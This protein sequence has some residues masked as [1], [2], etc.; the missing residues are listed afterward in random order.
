MNLQEQMERLR[1]R[2]AAEWYGNIRS[3][4]A[5][6]EELDRF[7]SWLAES[8]LNSA[9][10]LKIVALSRE[11]RMAARDAGLS[12]RPLI[13]LLDPKVI[14]LTESRS[15]PGSAK[16]GQALRRPRNLILA[17]ASVLIVVTA[18]VV[19][20][21]YI[22]STRYSTQAGEQRTVTLPDGSMMHMNSQSS[23]RVRMSVE[24]RDIDLEGEAFFQVAHDSSRPF[25]VHTDNVVVRAV[26]TAFNV[27]TRADGTHVAVSEGKVQLSRE[28]TPSAMRLLSRPQQ[29]AER[30][31]LIAGEAALAPPE[32]TIERRSAT[33]AIN[34]L[35]WREH[36]LVLDGM[37]LEQVVAEFN[38]HQTAM[39]LR[40]EKVRPGTHHYS[41]TF[42]LNDPSAFVDVLSSEPDLQIETRGNEVIIRE[43]Q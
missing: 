7:S 24:Q 26:G 36:M 14:P 17:A 10:Y 15:E 33:D 37:T 40:L 4:E 34:A 39:R 12:G 1:R 3:G 8:P 41:G 43:R 19:G 27:S 28:R 13:P 5:D 6:A 11:T 9:A 16:A 23:V 22:T 32:G 29:D 42:Y 25:R 20:N 31:A 21:F 18:I 2:Q 35:A 30:L 38:K